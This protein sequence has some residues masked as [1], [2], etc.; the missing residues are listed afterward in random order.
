M[1]E[2][3]KEDTIFGDVE[4][5]RVTYILLVTRGNYPRHL[6]ICCSQTISECITYV[7]R[8]EMRVI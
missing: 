7:G 3:N 8:S 1:P 4:L 2:L 6:Y 5:N